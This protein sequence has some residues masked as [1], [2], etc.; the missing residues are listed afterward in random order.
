MI[1]LPRYFQSITKSI[2]LFI[3]LVSFNKLF[4]AEGGPCKDYGEC[5]KFQYSLNDMSLF[6]E[7]LLH[8]LII[9]MDAIPSNIQDGEE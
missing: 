6:K 9:A 2:A 8:I 4:A 5:D 3:L 1:S 7:G